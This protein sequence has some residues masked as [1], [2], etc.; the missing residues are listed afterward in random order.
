MI[1]EEVD[2]K[3][4]MEEGIGGEA[5]N[6]YRQVLSAPNGVTTAFRPSWVEVVPKG[7]VQPRRCMHG[8]GARLGSVI[9]GRS[10]IG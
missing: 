6:R 4:R 7:I 9:G 1:I 3:I 5:G 10:I 2:G 8:Q